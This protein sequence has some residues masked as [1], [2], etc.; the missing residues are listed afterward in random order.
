LRIRDAQAL[1]GEFCPRG[2]IAERGLDAALTKV[3]QEVRLVA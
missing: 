1:H 2:I 3:L